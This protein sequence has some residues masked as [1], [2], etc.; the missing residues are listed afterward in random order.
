M[1]S[2]ELSWLKEAKSHVGLTENLA[3]GK[4]NP[5]LLGWLKQLNAFWSDSKTP[6]CGVFIA[7]CMQAVGLPYPKEYFRALSWLNFGTKLTKPCY[8]CVAV[9]TRT[10]GGHVT[11]VVGK[12]EDGRLVCLGGN[13]ADSVKYSVYSADAFKAFVWVGKSFPLDV[14]YELPIIKNIQTGSLKED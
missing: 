4:P 10:G 1:I 9:K 14:R 8:G 11:F 2:N 7:H 12:L 6:W 13:Q 3:N 5:V